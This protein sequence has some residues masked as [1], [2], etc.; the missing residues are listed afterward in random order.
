[1]GSARA[2]DLLGRTLRDDPAAALAALGPEVDDP[3]RRADHL[4]VVLDDDHGVPLL[5]QRPQH[6]QQLEDVVEV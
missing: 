3:V 4:E 2:R 6:A 1:V 5:G